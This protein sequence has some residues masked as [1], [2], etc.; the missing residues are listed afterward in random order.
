MSLDGER[1]MK[2]MA[3]PVTECTS[4]G[5]TGVTWYD[6]DDLG[7]HTTVEE[8]CSTCDGTGEVAAKRDDEEAA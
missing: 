2:F 5:G 7:T 3:P 1:P 6:Y 4:C 8:R